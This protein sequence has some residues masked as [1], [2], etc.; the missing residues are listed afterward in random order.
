MKFLESHR[1]TRRYHPFKPKILATL[2]EIYRKQMPPGSSNRH[3]GY[4]R[5][6]CIYPASGS[7]R[8]Y[9]SM[10]RTR[11][12]VLLTNHGEKSTR[13][14]RET[15]SLSRSVLRARITRVGRERDPG[16]KSISVV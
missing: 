4:L 2:S 12:Y 13:E 15:A 10:C 6:V 5:N 9:I 3:E 16:R 1:N 7:M 14:Q 8:I 11:E